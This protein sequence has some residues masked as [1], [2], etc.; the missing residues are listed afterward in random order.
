[1]GGWGGGNPILKKGGGGSSEILKRALKRYQD[2]VLWAWLEMFFAPKTYLFYLPKICI[3]IVLDFSLDIFMSQEKL[4]TM[5]MQ[6][7]GG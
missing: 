3:G 4:Q 5:I 1:M 2:P 7:F 6:I